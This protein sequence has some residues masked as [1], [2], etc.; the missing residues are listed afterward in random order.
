MVSSSVAAIG[1]AGSTGTATV[2]SGTWTNAGELRVGYNGAG[3]LV[4]GSGGEVAVGGSLFQ[5][6]AGSIDLGPGGVLRIGLGNFLRQMGMTRIGDTLT[7][8]FL[9][10]TVRPRL[11]QRFPGF[12]VAAFD[13]ALQQRDG[14]RPIGLRIAWLHPLILLLATPLVLRAWFRA[15]DPLSLG[16]LLCILVGVTANALATGALS[17]P[18]DRYQARIAW[19]LP[20]AAMLFWRPA[21]GRL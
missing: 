7:G 14:L 15:R 20:L 5:G 16:L 18:Y 10:I 12:E 17:G 13:A 8:N 1:F 11:V 9:D 21:P 2:T 3:A 6:T 19:L 4:I